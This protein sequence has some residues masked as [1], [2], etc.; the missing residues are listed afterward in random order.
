M[1]DWIGCMG[2]V[3]GGRFNLLLFFFSDGVRQSSDPYGAYG[4]GGY[5]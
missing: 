4:G 3:L 1:K 5:T 2:K